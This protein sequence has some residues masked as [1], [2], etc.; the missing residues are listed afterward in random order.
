MDNEKTRVF[1]FQDEKYSKFWEISQSGVVVTVRYGKSDT[2]GQSQTK[3][4]GNVALADKR[5][6][7]AHV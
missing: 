3:T 5:S 4:L 7:E 6:E 1:V 2:T